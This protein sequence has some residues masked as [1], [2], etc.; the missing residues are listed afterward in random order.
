MEEQNKQSSEEPKVPR[1]EIHLP[2]FLVQEKVGLG[3][4]IKRV[5]YRLG[6]KRPCRGCDQRAAALDRWMVFTPRR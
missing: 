1:H 4:A 2:G 3:A 5:T 6:V